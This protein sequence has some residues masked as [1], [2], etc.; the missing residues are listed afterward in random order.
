MEVKNI[1][2]KKS[3]QLAKSCVWDKSLFPSLHP[4]EVATTRGRR[5]N[6]MTQRQCMVFYETCLETCLTC[7][8]PEGEI[9]VTVSHQNIR[10]EG[11]D[12]KNPRQKAMDDDFLN[13]LEEESL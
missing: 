13:R 7:F 6:S 10:H 11:K 4:K 1:R 5:W 8:S 9:G 2:M 3:H 12:Q